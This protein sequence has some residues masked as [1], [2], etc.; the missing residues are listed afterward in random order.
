MGT[1]RRGGAAMKVAAAQQLPR[2][3]L[4][5][6]TTSP[7]PTRGEPLN[8]VIYNKFGVPQGQSDGVFTVPWQLP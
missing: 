7:A 2:P 8:G 1:S 4:K 6:A 5:I 3:P